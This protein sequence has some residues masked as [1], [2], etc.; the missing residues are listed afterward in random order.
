MQKRNTM[1]KL[2]SLLACLTA[3]VACKEA[4]STISLSDEDKSVAIETLQLYQNVDSQLVAERNG[5]YQLLLKHSEP[6]EE[7][8]EEDKGYFLR[9]IVHIDS[10]VNQG[11][12]FVKENKISELLALL[13]AELPNFYAHPHNFIDNEI[14]LHQL[15]AELYRQTAESYE[16]YANKVIYL[17]DF[18]IVHIEALENKHPQYGSILVEQVCSCIQVGQYNKAILNGEKLSAYMIQTRD[19]KGYIYASLLLSKA[20]EKAGMPALQDSTISSVKNYPQYE[21]C[22]EDLK[23]VPMFEN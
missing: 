14:M 9:N 16:E 5:L 19:E 23:D 12:A 22:C 3:L 18:T 7:A 20:Y 21:A 17:N 15:L 13:E 11:A 6:T 4:K 8:S 2:F 10:V 1:K